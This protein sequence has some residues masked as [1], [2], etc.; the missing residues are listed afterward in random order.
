MARIDLKNAVIRILDGYAAAALVN[1]GSNYAAG[2]STMDINTVSGDASATNLPVGVAFT[3]EGCPVVHTVT[4]RSGGPPNTSITFTPVLTDVVLDN[5]PIVFIG[6]SVEVNIGQGKMS[7]SEKRNLTYELSKGSL[8]SVKQ[9]DEQPVEVS[10]DFVWDFLTAISGADTPTI[11]DALKNRGPASTWVSSSA[12]PCEPY[13][14]DIM[15]EYIPPCG[16][17]APEVVVLPD[18]RYE[19]LD[20]NF[21]DATV[22]MSGKCNTVEASVSRSE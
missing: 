22:S 3:V 11:E 15:V 10:M 9:G 19:S 12:D 13:A 4:A 6:Q 14:V 1:N 8:D 2:D 16:G 18:F 20:H 21:T 7:Y 17:V 5:A